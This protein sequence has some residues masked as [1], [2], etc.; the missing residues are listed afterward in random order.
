MADAAEDPRPYRPCVGLMLFSDAGEVFVGNRAD[1]E[2]EHWQMPQGGID[3]GE[4]PRD[5]ALRE[6]REEIGT[7]KAIILAESKDW[8]PYDFPPG[9]SQSTRGGKYRGQTQRWFALRFTGSDDDIDLD[10]HDME[11]KA[12]RWVALDH[13]ETLIVPFKR[14]VYRKVIEEFRGY[15][16]PA[17]RITGC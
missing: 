2:G 8:L 1:L 16:Q 7:D 4:S 5:A 11:F 17:G 6:L 15:A 13:L 9:V 3:D 12:W 14:P 10:A